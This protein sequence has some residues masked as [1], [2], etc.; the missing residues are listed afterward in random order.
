MIDSMFK[1]DYVPERAKCLKQCQ[2]HPPSSTACEM[3]Y[4]GR[5]GCWAHKNTVTTAGGTDA[6]KGMA[7]CWPLGNCRTGMSFSILL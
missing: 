3:H 2:A 1:G 7:I 5:K 4:A 6:Q